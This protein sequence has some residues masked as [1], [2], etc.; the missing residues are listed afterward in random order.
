MSSKNIIDGWRF[1]IQEHICDV[2]RDE[3]NEREDIQKRRVELREKWH[4]EKY[5]TESRDE[6]WVIQNKIDEDVY[7][8]GKSMCFKFM[9]D[10]GGDGFSLCKKHLQEIVNKIKE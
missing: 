3:I 2:C 5:K 9:A 1:M 6:L 4:E 7:E 10:C 8:I